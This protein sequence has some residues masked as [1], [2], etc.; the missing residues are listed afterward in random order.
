MLQPGV[1]YAATLS[2]TSYNAAPNSQFDHVFSGP[3]NNGII[4]VP[5]YRNDA[6][7]LDYNSNFI[8]NPYPSAISFDL[9]MAENGYRATNT[10]GTL[11][12]AVYLW[13]HDSPL[14]STANGNSALNFGN[15]DYA[16]IN[17]TGEVAGGD[18]N[19]DGVI[20][21]ADEPNRYIPSGQGFF[22]NYH[23]SGA[24]S[25]TATNPSE[26]N[27]LISEGT[28]TFRNAMR[29]AGNN[30]QFFKSSNMP[31]EDNKLWLLLSSDNGINSQILV[32][33]KDGATNA[34][35]GGR[36]DARRNASTGMAAFLYSIIENSTKKYAIQGKATESLN[37]NEIIPLGIYT[38]ISAETTYTI[39]ISHY[40]GDFF[41]NNTIYLK[42]KLLNLTHS[43]SDSNYAFTSEIGD[44]TERFEIV[45]VTNGLSTNDYETI[46]N[47]IS[48][49]ELQNND[50]KFTYHGNSTIKS[51][52]I[53]D[54]LGREIYQ[55]RGSANTEVFNLSNLSSAV[56]VA[57]IKLSNGK[58]ISKKAIK[59]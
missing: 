8:G 27:D 56:Y 25:A 24:V 30:N 18:N 54:V 3:F 20:T 37:L 28:V 39:S 36:F 5:V 50:V 38:T 22:V 7:F 59:K 23:N 41:N 14:S 32:G 4:S 55:F 48:I 47:S 6:E 31:V 58:L 15:S 9:F 13:S 35:D 16:I 11:D 17:E 44:F 33:Y 10:S 19:N 12:G 46:S 51:V 52:K 40:Q 42:D 21:A 26:N 43:L 2:T 34:D 1:G 57:Q 49:I 53:V 29:V 45:F